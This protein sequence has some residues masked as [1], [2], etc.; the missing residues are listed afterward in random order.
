LNVE[1]LLVIDFISTGLALILV[2][3]FSKAYRLT[4][5]T[6]LL[7]FQ[8]GFLYLALSYI[9]LAIFKLYKN[10]A[11]IS[12]PFLWLRLIVQSYGF[13]FIAF[14]YHFSKKTEKTTKYFLGMISLSSAIFIA[15]FFAA[16]II[17]P[18]FLELPSMDIV[19]ESFR[20]ANLVFLG[21]TIYIIVKR[22]ESSSEAISGLIWTILGFSL[23]WLSQYSMLIWGIDDSQTAFV[24]AHIARLASLTLFLYIYYSS[25][26][27]A[28]ESREAH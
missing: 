18:P 15:L 2:Y 5:S 24:F 9:F 22:F 3:L 6:Y 27:I 8:I 11:T 19:S 4:R 21:Y 12:E 1:A 26:R 7:G 23:L 16:L 13:S 17:A 28:S 14:S 20:I 10:N 25:G